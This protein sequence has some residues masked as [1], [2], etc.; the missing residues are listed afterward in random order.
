MTSDLAAEPPSGRSAPPPDRLPVVAIISASIGAGHDGAAR[1]LARRL[2]IAGYAVRRHDFLDLLPA[3]WGETIRASYAGQLRHAPASWGW[4]LRADDGRRCC[5]AAS[6]FAARTAAARM[7]AALGRDVTAVVSTYP[8][9]GQGLATGAPVISY[10]C[11]PGHGTANA[12]VLARAG[13]SPWPLN[14]AE[15]GAL[16]D[17]AVDGDLRRRQNLPYARLVAASDAATLI[18][19]AAAAGTGRATAEAVPA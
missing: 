14:R 11:L 7:R 19:G 5:P 13:L 18:A 4:L 9:A 6:G 10:R 1:E 17:R 2:V 12:A 8:Q 15:L 16:L 3:G